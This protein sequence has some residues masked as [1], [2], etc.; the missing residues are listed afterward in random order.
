MVVSI[1]SPCCQ[2]GDL[3]PGVRCGPHQRSRCVKFL[4]YIKRLHCIKAHSIL[5]KEL[6]DMIIK[7]VN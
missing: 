1:L 4:D 5:I 7:S 2:C 6:Q 3:L